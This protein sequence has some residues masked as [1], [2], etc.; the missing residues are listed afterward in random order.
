[1]SKKRDRPCPTGKLSYRN[2]RMAETALQQVQMRFASFEVMPVRAYPCNLC[3]G[4]H[5]TSL[6][7]DELP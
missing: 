4:W 3:Y 7:D 5:L 1:M 6:P 2:K